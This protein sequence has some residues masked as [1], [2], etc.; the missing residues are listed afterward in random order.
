VRGVLPASSPRQSQ[1][2]MNAAFPV[3]DQN[4]F[5]GLGIDVNDDFVN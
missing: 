2:G 5:T 1:F 4:D 3:N